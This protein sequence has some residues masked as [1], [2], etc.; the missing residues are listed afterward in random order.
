MRITIAG[1]GYVG[2]ITGL[3]LCERGQ[4]VTMIDIDEKKIQTL[5][6]GIPPF[7]EKGLPE[8]LESC[9]NSGRIK[10]TTDPVE[11]YSEPDTVM[12]AVPT[13]ERRDGSA[14][15]QYVFDVCS[16]IAEHCRKACVVILKSTSPVGTSDKIET[17]LNEKSNNDLF[18]VA[19]NP[20]F[21]A[22]GTAINDTFNA[23]R[24]VIG[25]KNLDIAEKVQD[26]YTGFSSTFVLTDR[27]SA[28]MIKYASN[29][30]LALKISYINE[31]AN[32]CEKVGANVEIVAAGMGLDPRIGNLY[33]KP[34]TGY[35]GSC[36]PK[37]TK[38]LHWLAKY[39]GY[40]L[41][42]IKATIEVNENQKIILFQKARQ[43]YQNFRGLTV[44]VLGLAFKPGTDDIREAPSLDIVRLFEE[45]GAKVKAWDFAASDNFRKY[46][47]Q[48]A[49]FCPTAE[50][51]LIGADMCV[52]LTEWDE[53]KSLTPKQYKERMK[54]PIVLDGRNCYPPE[55]FENTSVLYDSIGRIT[56]N[57]RIRLI[58]ELV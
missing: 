23:S 27:K 46:C 24:I 8:L 39:H 1:A 56:V 36:F 10:F 18:E 19:S 40:E 21:L 28:E 6:N 43:Y 33:L 51:T 50:E 52:I 3:C 2:L 47:S 49:V 54:T 17:F 38:A 32:L 41:K 14:N 34:G 26:I 55:V 35:G 58:P 9:Q 31:I 45:E 11:A 16:L 48:D 30:F 53:V 13:P 20:E 7:F 37:D 22:Q 5:Q 12:I 57:P 15:L 42:T 44:A 25:A 4:D 29:D